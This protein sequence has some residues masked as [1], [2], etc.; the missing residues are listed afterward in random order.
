[1]GQEI[2]PE[3]LR[4]ERSYLEART[5]GTSFS[6]LPKEIQQLESDIQRS[7]DAIAHMESTV[8]GTLEGRQIIRS[9]KSLVKQKTEAEKKII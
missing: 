6:E 3:M 2:T 7:K 1:L 5:K 8:G 4:A 9:L